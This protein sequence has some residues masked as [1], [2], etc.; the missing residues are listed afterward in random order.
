MH[1]D[2]SFVKDLVGHERIQD[3]MACDL[4][5]LWGTTGDIRAGYFYCHYH[6]DYLA[7]LL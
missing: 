1:V 2:P 5:F 6:C 4:F 7:M 3:E